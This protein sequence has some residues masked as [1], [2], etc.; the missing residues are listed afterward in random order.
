[1]G[2][3][4]SEILFVVPHGFRSQKLKKLQEAESL[5]F[6][7]TVATFFL[8]VTDKVFCLMERFK[9]SLSTMSIMDCQL[10]H[11]KFVI[12]NITRLVLK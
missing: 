8:Y 2:A 3:A 6:C 7:P 1:M 9:Q 10:L 4:W 11:Q 12:V 5:P